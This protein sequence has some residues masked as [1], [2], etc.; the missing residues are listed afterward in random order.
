MKVELR[1][2]VADDIPALVADAR[3]QDV[4]EMQA[5]GDGYESALHKSL[6]LSTWAATGLVDGVPVCMFGVAP[7]SVLSGTGIPWMLG[8]N[9]LVRHEKAFLRRCRRAV[10]V[11][12]DTYPSLL[13]VVDERNTTAKKWLAWLGFRFDP[14]SFP[15]GGSRFRVF[16]AGESHV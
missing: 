11:M 10:A 4:A 15:L 5:L 7:G 9:A 2:A 3:P 13:N 14:H 6:A 16:R 1:E 12:L 8:T